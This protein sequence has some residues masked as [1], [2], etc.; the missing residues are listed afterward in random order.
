ME[1][2]LLDINWRKEIAANVY[3]LASIAP[4]LKYFHAAAGF[5]TKDTWLKAI[6]CGNYKLL[7]GVTMTNVK[8]HFL[9]S[10]E[11]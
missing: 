8:K 5:P 9:E 3:A 7:P 4:A 11:T 6:E 10:I 2:N 1:F